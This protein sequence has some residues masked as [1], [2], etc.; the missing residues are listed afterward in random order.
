MKNI[1][2]L[3]ICLCFCLIIKAQ[4]GILDPSFGSNGT[5]TEYFQPGNYLPENGQRVLNATDGKKYVIIDRSWG[6][7][8]LARYNSTGT[9]DQS[10]GNNGYIELSTIRNVTDAL[11]QP[12]NKIVLLYP[13]NEC[14]NAGGVFECYTTPGF[15]RLNPDGTIDQSFGTNGTAKLPA[16]SGYTFHAMSLQDNGSIVAAGQYYSSETLYDF[17]VIRLKPDGALDPSFDADGLTHI[18]VGSYYD[19]AKAVAIQS[20]GKVIVG[21][22]TY[23][24]GSGTNF[25]LIRLTD[26]GSL[27]ASFGEN[28]ITIRNLFSDYLRAITLQADGKIV[29]VGSTYYYEY[30]ENSGYNIEHYDILVT[31]FTSD[32]LPDLTFGDNGLVVT[33]LGSRELTT[34]VVVQP[35][36]KIV[37]GGYKESE[38]SFGSDFLV[39]RYTTT[40]ALDNGFDGDGIVTTNVRVQDY[41]NHLSLSNDGKIIITGS[42]FDPV[43]CNTD[44]CGLTTLCRASQS[45]YC[46]IVYNPDGSANPAF[47]IDGIVLGHFINWETVFTK[48]AV[49]PSGKL[50]AAGWSFDGTNYDL[51]LARYNK[52]GTLDNTFDGDGKLVTDISLASYE[53]DFPFAVQNDGKILLSSGGFSRYDRC[54]NDFILRRYNSDGSI[55][56]SFGNNGIVTTDFSSTRDRLISIAILSDGKILAVGNT[57]NSTSN[58]GEVAV[59][60]YNPDGNLDATFSEDGKLTLIFDPVSGVSSQV[61]A[62]AV[63]P[64]DKFVLLGYSS[65][66]GYALGRFTVDGTPDNTFSGDG[67]T[68]VTMD[69]RRR[70]AGYPLLVQQDN[71]I[72]YV[73]GSIV[74]RYTADGMLDNSFDNDGQL[75]IDFGGEMDQVYDVQVQ[76]NGKL[77][78]SGINEDNY[79]GAIARFNPDGTID[80]SFGTDG[81]LS[82]KLGTESDNNLITDMAIHEDRLYAVGEY[83]HIQ[84]GEGTVSAIVIDCIKQTYYQDADGDGYGN[85]EAT[86]LDCSAPPNYVGQAGD[87]DDTD[88][89]VY[90]SAPEVCDEKDNDC[91]GTIDEDVKI[92]FYYDSDADGYGDINTTTLACAAPARYVSTAGDCNDANAA[93]KPGATEVCDGIDNNCDGQVDEDCNNK[94]LLNI[95]SATVYESKGSVQ[96]TV[97]LSRRVP[98][99]VTVNY[100]TVEGTARTRSTKNN[101]A[102]FTAQSGTLTFG[103]TEQVKTITIQIANGGADRND[104]VEPTEQ[105]T[106]QLSKPSGA[107]ISNG[108][109]TVTI[110][111][112]VAPLTSADVTRSKANPVTSEATADEFLIQAL[113]NPSRGQFTLRTRNNS[114][115]GVQVRVL[116]NLGRV[117]ESRTSPAGNM[118]LSFG[119]GYRPGVYFVEVVQGTERKLLKLVKQ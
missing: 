32:G 10:Y 94:P 27:D 43:P 119:A 91:D 58:R 21:G 81:Y 6:G 115:Q 66:Q 118:T 17:G 4:Q 87:C 51:S 70:W 111:D 110:L 13:V 30:D 9:L 47:D 35:D 93:I 37:V 24:G 45:D 78:V 103:P 50:V 74:T 22:E 49:D 75:E 73:G 57:I 113:P 86:I 23:Y 89:D 72:V 85:A 100:A 107:G 112:G 20:D 80:N 46:L 60:R 95:T 28:G 104:A 116:D 52:D 105:F 40:G 39:L 11:I 53:Y 68:I 1:L 36:G 41:A 16:N 77:I 99:G 18:D 3:T 38:N 44:P 29:A 25:G 8:V 114:A 5:F 69:Q 48:A 26:V 79:G 7:T 106:V 108:V 98:G 59:A 96:L 76:Y 65:S 97:T 84:N 63:A 42:A 2:T 90:P 64:N 71:K 56:L 15:S 61:Y 31:R 117:V 12:G 67:T 14:I 92:T 109:G 62:V 101:P 102:D 88:D 82:I 34:S 19:A 54:T 55:D 83:W 33:D